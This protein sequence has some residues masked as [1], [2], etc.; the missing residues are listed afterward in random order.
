LELFEKETFGQTRILIFEGLK[1]GETIKVP[2]Y[3]EDEESSGILMAG[4]LYEIGNR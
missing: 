2:Y 4:L 3:H 1:E